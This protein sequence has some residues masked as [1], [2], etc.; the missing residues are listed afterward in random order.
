MAVNGLTK[1][2]GHTMIVLHYTVVKQ[3]RQEFWLRLLQGRQAVRAGGEAAL[4]P[5]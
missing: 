2:C 4:Q 3:Q 5:A 1:G